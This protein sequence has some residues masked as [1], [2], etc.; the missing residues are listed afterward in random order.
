MVRIN[1]ENIEA[2]GKT[3]ADYLKETGYN[4]SRVAVEQ[5]ENIVPKSE[6]E[7]V[8][9]KDGDVIE[10]VNFTGGG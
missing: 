6:Y 7:T 8:V 9:M 1:G 4:S 5:N 3:I 10:V 2:A